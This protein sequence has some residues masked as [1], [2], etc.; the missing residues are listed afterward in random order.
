MQSILNANTDIL[1]SDIGGTNARFALVREGSGQLINCREYQCSEFGNIDLAIEHYLAEVEPSSLSRICLAVPG[2]VDND[3]INFVNNHWE[4]SQKA[5]QHTLQKPLLCINDF[6][7]Q[8]YYVNQISE[9]ELSWLNGNRPKGGGV[10]LVLGAGTG[11][12]VSAILPT[13]EL[14][15]SEAGHITFAP[16]NDHEMLVLKLLWSKYKRVSVERLLSGP[17]LENLY[18]A[19][20][21]IENGDVEA[22]N[23]EMS[24]PEIVAAARKG[25]PIARKT[26]EDFFNMFASVAGD[27]TIA[28]G[29]FDGVYLTG[30]VLPRLMDFFDQPKFMARFTAKGRF[31]NHCLQTPIALVIAD[32]PGLK[33]CALA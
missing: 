18:W 24:A 23:T 7:A 9:D 26:I 16:A 8:A 27:L 5:L 25:E 32:Q 13:G 15:P 19:N 12:G 33:G 14:V 22:S 31:S 21:C 4:F 10:K 2:P 6:D 29:A 1:V 3:E 28:M 17:G 30:G 11:L 20:N